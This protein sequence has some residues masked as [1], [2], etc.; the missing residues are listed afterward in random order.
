MHEPKLI[1]M[2]ALLFSLVIL[3]SLA[4]IFVSIA[5]IICEQYD[6]YTRKKMFRK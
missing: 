6:R 2:F 3:S 5:P 1:L 4:L